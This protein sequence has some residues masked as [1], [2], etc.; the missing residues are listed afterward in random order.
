LIREAKFDPATHTYVC[1]KSGLVV[2]SC[3]QVLESVGLIDYRFVKQSVLD[4]KGDIGTEVH[5]LCAVIDRG[6][7]LEDY[8]YD[9]RLQPYLDSYAS[10][11]QVMRWKPEKIEYGPYIA[12][13]GSMPV[14]FTVDRVG[15]ID[16]EEAVV[17]LKCTSTDEPSHSIQTAGYDMCLGGGKR[18]RRYTVRLQGDG[19]MAK[20]TPHTDMSEYGVFLSALTIAH[21]KS[22]KGYT[23]GKG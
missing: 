15:L 23:N 1:P 4:H 12:D 18:R 11:V 5:A 21:W 14:G 6:E 17:E 22:N 13:V 16:S 19:K 10:F 2:P 9:P 20:L 7:R 3:T 8:E